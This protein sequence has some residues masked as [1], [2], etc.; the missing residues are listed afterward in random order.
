MAFEA[1]V[2]AFVHKLEEGGWAG[3]I[4][5]ALLVAA[6]AAVATLF[7]FSQFKGLSHEK[8]MDQAQLA[9]EIARGHGFSTLMIR[10]RAMTQ[11]TE[12]MGMIPGS[13]PDTYNAP[14]N[15]LLNA[16]FLLL[17]RKTW[18]MTTKDVIYSSD[19]MIAGVQI[20]CFVLAVWVNFLTAQ[21]LFD[22]RLALLGMGLMLVASVFWKF[23]IAG[24]PQNLMLLIFSGCTYAL[25]RAVE[26]LETPEA[27]EEQQ[28]R[29]PTPWLVMAAACFGLLALTHAL[30][31]WI[32]AG[33]LLFAG[34]VFR[35]RWKC[36][37]I[38]AAVFTLIYSPW[39]VRNFRVCHNPAGVAI[40]SLLDQVRGSEGGVMRSFDAGFERDDVPLFRKKLQTQITA[41]I[42][43]AMRFFGGS[44]IAPIFFLTLLHIFKRPAIAIFRWAILSMWVAAVFGMAFIGLNTDGSLQAN[45]LHVLF[46]PMMIFYGLAL[47]LFLWARLEINI[48]LVRYAF[49]TLIYLVS[50]L[51]FI[52]MLVAQSGGR[53]QWP[54][55]VPPFIAILNTWIEPRE[56]IASDM[57]WAVAWYADRRSLWLPQS[58]KEFVALYDSDRLA[59]PVAALYLTPVSGNQPFLSDIA[60]GEY[61]DW[62]AFITR[63]V[64]AKDFPL[65]A[66]TAL[67]LNNQCVLYADRDRWSARTD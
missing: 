54:P 32:F 22:R 59:G 35:P 45:D 42:S 4:R 34:T 17:T 27:A 47:A 15:P 55:Y 31:I 14:L 67:P 37:L 5:A 53:V 11:L 50:A 24:L 65:R 44:I 49:F 9:R 40:Y 64:N 56:I 26:T 39:L 18:E 43:N 1:E 19:R 57:P 7:L 33:A 60:T 61:K 58:I 10:P 12:N 63:T 16:P 36:V 29:S 25:V 48:R 30:T 3:V 6:I 66:V 2:Q 51:E 62:A 21:R 28:P 38:M 20:L 13:I 52:G 41:Q 46:I 23:A 8:A